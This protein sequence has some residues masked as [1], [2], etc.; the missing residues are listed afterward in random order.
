MSDKKV[1]SIELF[2]YG[3]AV[4]PEIGAVEQGWAVKVNYDDN[5]SMRYPYSAL[6]TAVSF[7][8]GAITDAAPDGK[9]IKVTFNE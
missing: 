9:Y 4:V 1:S 7:I 6:S 8:D 2:P 5:S 3:G